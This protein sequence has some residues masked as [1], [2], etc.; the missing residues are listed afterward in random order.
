[1][2]VWLQLKR[3]AYIHIFKYPVELIRLHPKIALIDKHRRYSQVQIQ[4]NQVTIETSRQINKLFKTA[5]NL[6]F[7][8]WINI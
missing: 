7:I 8:V 5:E 2:V 1:M 4:E 3:H 6:V